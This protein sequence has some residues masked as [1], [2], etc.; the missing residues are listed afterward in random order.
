MKKMMFVLLLI[1]SIGILAAVESD[2]SAVVGYVKYPCV[3]GLNL[4]ALPMNAGYAWASDL[5]NAYLG[6]MDTI[7]YWDNVSQ[8][9]VAAS[10]IGYWDGDFEVAP[11]AVLF[12]NA[13]APF[14]LFS[15][16]AMPAA[17]AS[18]P[19]LV[20]LNTM[21]IPLNYSAITLAS[22]LGAAVGT[23]DTINYWDS[24]TQ[25]WVAASDIG[26]WD[27]DFA[28]T[29]GMPLLVNALAD[30]TWPAGPRRTT[31]NLRTSN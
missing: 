20:G 5:A 22:E 26:Y 4:V 18:Y 1:V 7:N 23:L 31:T 29:I 6:Y 14:N 3:T 16:G 11:G 9:W 15:L 21:M 10:D 27:G 12:V 24:A 25:S 8:S 19:L 2:P 17:N 28:T 30:G 13:V